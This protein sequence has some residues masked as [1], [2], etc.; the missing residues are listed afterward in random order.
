MP[1]RRFRSSSRPGPRPVLLL[2]LGAAAGAVLGAAL[3]GRVRGGARRSAR[4]GR[5]AWDPDREGG[6]PEVIPAEVHVEDELEADDDLAALHAAGL[7]DAV[8]EG[9]HPALGSGPGA[10]VA[11]HREALE[12]EDRVL[13]VFLNDPVLRERAVDISAVGPGTIALAGWVR[14]S[15]EIDHAATLAGGV[16]GVQQVVEHLVVRTR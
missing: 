6:G 9:A 8:E 4:D 14:A 10:Q 2:A 16:P 1:I 7:G 15:D 3:A 13:E 12:L 5:A 11:R